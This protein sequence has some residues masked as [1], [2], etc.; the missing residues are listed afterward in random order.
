MPAT[1]IPSPVLSEEPDAAAYAAGAAGAPLLCHFWC[2][3][4]FFGVPR[5]KC[6]LCGGKNA[7]VSDGW[8][9]DAVLTIRHVGAR[10]SYV[11]RRRWKC[12]ECSKSKGEKK[13]K[14]G[15]SW[16]SD[17]AIFMNECPAHVQA[18]YPALRTS[19]YDK[20]LVGRDLADFIRAAVP[21]G[22]L[23]ET[24]NHIRRTALDGAA[25]AYAMYLHH[26]TQASKQKSSQTKLGQYFSA[27]VVVTTSSPAS[28]EEVFAPRRLASP[29]WIKEV[30]LFIHDSEKDYKLGYVVSCK[31]YSPSSRT[32]RTT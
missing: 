2:A 30:Y 26:F 29:P 14:K 32:I 23:V 4:T 18:S 19:G 22:T 12:K 6:P 13:A 31:T 28:Y 10:Q 17:D 7:L 5:P 20:T 16:F 8:P 25:Q 15:A 27:D 3:Q 1:L 11:A 24:S 21:Q 9:D